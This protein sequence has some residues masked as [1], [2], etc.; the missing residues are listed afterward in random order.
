MG[1]IIPGFSKRMKRRGSNGNIID[2]SDNSILFSDPIFE[3]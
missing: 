3:Y 2:D 1:M